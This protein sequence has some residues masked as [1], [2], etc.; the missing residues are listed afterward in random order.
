MHNNPTNI[1]SDSY[2]ED[3]YYDDLIRVTEGNTNEKLAHL[4]I[5]KS[6]ELTDWLFERGIKFQPAL[7]G[8]LSLGR[9]N[10]FFLGGG[11]AMLNALYRTAIRLKVK[12]LCDTEV[13]KLNI[14]DNKFKS[15]VLKEN[16]IETNIEEQLLL[17]LQ[18][19]FKVMKVG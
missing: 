3:E 5:Q 19:V 4:T 18:E 7:G 6:A 12:C 17:L 13:L 1:L 8:T 14:I 9:T 15:A 11:R 2:Q 16:D 10:A